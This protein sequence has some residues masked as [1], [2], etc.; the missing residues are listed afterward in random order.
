MNFIDKMSTVGSTKIIC[1]N[2]ENPRLMS[3]QF[4]NRPKKDFEK[5]VDDMKDMASSHLTLNKM[6]ENLKTATKKEQESDAQME[7]EID[8]ID[9]NTHKKIQEEDNKIKTAYL[10]PEMDFALNNKISLIK[11]VFTFQDYIV[12]GKGDTFTILAFNP[13]MKRIRKKITI[14]IPKGENEEGQNLWF[15]RRPMDGISTCFYDHTND[16]MIM[17]TY[18]QLL[19][20]IKD[21]FNVKTR[22]I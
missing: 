13:R 12:F 21:C 5:E 14:S 3:I 16:V 11:N 22:N 7:Q 18:R 15:F 10:R 4:K 6:M 1:Q 19:V 8:Q 20:V 9:Q 17:V 2:S